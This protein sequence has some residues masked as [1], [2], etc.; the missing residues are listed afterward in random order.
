MLFSNKITVHQI[1]VSQLAWTL[2]TS[3]MTSMQSE[4]Y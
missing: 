4:D 2:M 3:M 1:T